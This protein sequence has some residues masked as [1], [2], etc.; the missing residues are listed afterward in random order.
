MDWRGHM[1]PISSLPIL[2]GVRLLQSPPSPPPA[3]PSGSTGSRHQRPSQSP[4]PLSSPPLPS[5]QSPSLASHRMY[6]AHTHQHTPGEYQ[7]TRCLQACTPAPLTPPCPALHA[8]F[9][10]V[11]LVSGWCVQS[12]SQTGARAIVNVSQSKRKSIA[13]YLKLPPTLVDCCAFWPPLSL[14]FSC[15]SN[16]QQ[17]CSITPFERF[18]ATLRSLLVKS[19]YVLIFLSHHLII[20]TATSLL[21]LSTHPTVYFTF[22][23]LFIWFS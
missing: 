22:V 10:S 5:S 13:N 9:V 16:K 8:V 15:H 19:P 23:L 11:S 17:Q 2:P 6:R 1:Q 7:S 20:F 4:V 21:I 18:R 12:K 3:K 14:S